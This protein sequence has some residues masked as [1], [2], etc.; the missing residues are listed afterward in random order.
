MSLRQR[1]KEINSDLKKQIWVFEIPLCC[2]FSTFTREDLLKRFL[3]CNS[4]IVPRYNHCFLITFEDYF[5]ILSFTFRRPLFAK[6]IGKFEIYYNYKEAKG[7]L[8]PFPI[9]GH[10][11]N[12]EFISTQMMKGYWKSLNN[13]L[14]KYIDN[15]YEK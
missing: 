12:D 11:S 14:K 4:L 15:N 13:I 6:K 10:Y 3:P 1:K 8:T 7:K 9:T 2:H 5:N